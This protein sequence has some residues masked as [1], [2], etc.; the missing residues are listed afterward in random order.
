MGH[1]ILRTVCH[2]RTIRYGPHRGHPPGVAAKLMLDDVGVHELWRAKPNTF[3][4]AGIYSH[5]KHEQKRNDRLIFT[6]IIS[7]QIGI[8]L[9]FTT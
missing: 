7:V 6:M 1:I 3:T 9:S 5:T 2:W 8:L 4:T